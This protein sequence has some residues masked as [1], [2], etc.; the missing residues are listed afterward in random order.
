MQCIIELQILILNKQWIINPL[1]LRCLEFEKICHLQNHRV[2]PTD[3]KGVNCENGEMMT[4]YV[5]CFISK[6]VFLQTKYNYSCIMKN[7]RFL[8]VIL[9][10]LCNH[11]FA[12]DFSAVAP[13]GQVL[14]Y[15]IVGYGE[16]VLASGENVYGTLVIPATVI[17]PSTNVT[18]SIVG[19]SN[20]AF[21]NC[22][23]LLSVQIESPIRKIGEHAFNGCQSLTSINIPNSVTEI[24]NYAFYECN[25]LAG[26]LDIPTSVVTIGMAAFH[27][28]SSLTSIIIPESISS[29]A[30]FTFS[31]CKSIST[32]VLPSSITAIG[33][34]AF[35]HCEQ[36]SSISLGESIISIEEGAFFGCNSLSSIVI[37]SSVTNIGSKIFVGCSELSSIIVNSNNNVFDS[38]NNC[39]AIIKTE[40]NILLYGCRS[41]IVPENIT[42]IDDDAFNGHSQLTI[43]SLPSVI[44]NIGGEA[45]KNCVGLVSITL[46]ENLKTIGWGAFYG[47]IGLQTVSI[48]NSVVSIGGNAFSSRANLN[49]LTIGKSVEIIE[50]GAFN[51]CSNLLTLN[52]NA[53]SCISVGG[54]QGNPIFENCDRFSN[55][56]IGENVR[57]IP[58][59]IFI[60]CN[61][62]VKINIPSTV[63]TIEKQAFQDCKNVSK[64]YLGSGLTYIGDNAFKGCI[65]L[66]EINYHPIRCIYMGNFSLPVFIGCPNLVTLSIGTEVEVLPMFAF[67]GCSSI[68]WINSKTIIPPII[69]ENTFEHLNPDVLLSVP[70]NAIDVYESSN[71][72]NLCNIQGLY[73][74][75]ISVESSDDLQGF[76]TII[77][78]ADCDNHNATIQAIPYEGFIF[79]HW[80]DGNTD[81]PRTIEVITDMSFTAYFKTNNDI[82]EMDG[83]SIKVYTADGV[84][85]VDG[86][87]NKQ[88]EL[89]NIHGQMVKSGI[90]SA[91]ITSI[92]VEITGMYLLR[93]GNSRIYKIFVTKE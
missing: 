71:Y 69:Q 67:S 5:L 11:L 50:G 70:C 15:D 42:S 91:S 48:P 76:V 93:I 54:S 61:G 51:D 44:E 7:T 65:S 79:D 86:A 43:I 80:N 78:N 66:E 22:Y 63:K 20:A 37:P 56:I 45:F 2:Y 40:S 1:E 46:P 57:V 14:Y 77:T 74:Y 25:S 88:F 84:V 90:F 52:Y 62:L 81:N 59:N 83:N 6:F 47:C 85:L 23:G 36:L 89:F 31:H 87:E 92:E 53:D 58:S 27:G 26:V 41:T 33:K 24:D 35:Q 9:L 10:T 18:Y 60:N 16:V 12:Y 34:F 39:N 30:D 29:I 32:I 17:Y 75:N 4:K 28:C 82:E 21:R 68:H 3:T 8:I 38:R 49:N 73:D 72:W 13:S 55:L 19:I 64:L